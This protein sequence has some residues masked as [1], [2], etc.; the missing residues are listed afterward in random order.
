M[1]EVTTLEQLTNLPEYK[2]GAIVISFWASWSKPSLQMNAVLEQLQKQYS[3]IKYVKV[4]AEEVEDITEKYEIE[5]VP[6]FVFL[7]NGNKTE[8]IKGAN[9]QE[10]TN[11][12]SNFGE[13]NA[14]SE[15]VVVSV[16][17]AESL[18]DRLKKLINSNKVMAFIKGT[19]SAPQCGFSSKFVTIL[20]DNGIQ[21]G[22]FN[23]LSDPDVRQGLKTYSNWPTYPQLY[24]N[25]ELVGGL[26]ILKELAD[27]GE[28]LSV[29]N[30]NK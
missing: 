27:E 8:L 18:N 14:P 29:V 6:S 2:N 26:D 24:V 12:I 23:I 11:A 30:G 20:K 19:P 28:L 17:P 22:S 21:F 25:G 10:L 1:I 15:P 13:K 7:K 5:S 9:P 3:S 16:Q 4:E